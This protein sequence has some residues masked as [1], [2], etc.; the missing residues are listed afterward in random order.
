[1]TS[2]QTETVLR[3]N[4][5]LIFAHTSFFFITGRTATKGLNTGLVSL[6]SHNFF[7]MFLII[8]STYSKHMDVV[9]SS[10][11]TALSPGHLCSARRKEKMGKEEG[12]LPHANIYTV[13]LKKNCTLLF[14]LPESNA[15]K[16]R[17]EVFYWSHALC[18]TQFPW[19]LWP[20]NLSLSYL[21]ASIIPFLRCVKRATWRSGL[22]QAK[23]TGVG[24]SVCVP[25]FKGIQLINVPRGWWLAKLN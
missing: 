18:W 7:F 12:K 9:I 22:G 16:P 3:N 4:N 14:N 6:K 24:E 5:A 13:I 21:T 23:E 8:M 25:V 15:F 20:C 1:M 17:L 19:L 2:S 11:C 10:S